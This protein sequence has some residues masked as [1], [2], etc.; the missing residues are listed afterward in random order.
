MQNYERTFVGD[1]TIDYPRALEQHSAYEDALRAHGAEVTTLDVNLGLPDSVFVEDT[2]V[3]LDEVAIIMSMGAVSRRAELAGIEPALRAH[4]PL[5]RVVLPGTIDGGDV[6][7][8]ERSL[9]VGHSSRTN[10]AGVQAFRDIV[11]PYGYT[12]TAVPVHGCLH[13][14]TACSSLPDGRFLVNAD[15]IDVTRL[16]SHILEV[17]THEPWAADVLV[18]GDRIIASDAFSDSIDLLMTNGFGV[19]PVAVSEFA[20][21][22]GGVTCLSLLFES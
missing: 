18:I 19:T 21:A 3:V 13:L 20:K 6:V 1:E 9:Y 16:N 15:C 7:R 11:R 22:E 2:A 12:V 17:P 4:R 10:T 14:K 5:A 8:A